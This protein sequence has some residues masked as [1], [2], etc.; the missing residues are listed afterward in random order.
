[1]YL[2]LRVT[3]GYIKEAEKLERNDS[4]INLHITLKKQLL[5]SLD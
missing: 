3:S 2:D 1:M 4:K 5:K